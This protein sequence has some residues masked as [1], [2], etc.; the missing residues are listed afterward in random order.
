MEGGTMNPNSDIVRTVTPACN[1]AI[2][3]AI[4]DSNPAS[5]HKRIS[6][7]CPLCPTLSDMVKETFLQHVGDSVAFRDAV[8]AM[9]RV[10]DQQDAS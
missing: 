2:D 3:R 1:E 10:M 4:H 7:V 5:F 9:S 6:G 8:K